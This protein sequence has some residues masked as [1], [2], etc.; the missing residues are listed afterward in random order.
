MR[1]LTEG[2]ILY[3]YEEL[4]KSAKQKANE[5]LEFELLFLAVSNL[6]SE[7]LLKNKKEKLEKKGFS[8]IEFY[9]FF[10]EDDNIKIDFS[11]DYVVNQNS[12]LDFK[13]FA[14]SI[15]LK[16]PFLFYR[17]ISDG[18]LSFTIS[19]R[20]YNIDEQKKLKHNIEINIDSEISNTELDTFLK[21]L[22]VTFETYYLYF[23]KTLYNKVKKEIEESTNNRALNNLKKRIEFYHNGL[24][25]ED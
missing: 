3:K 7:K 22:K 5:E 12:Y 21:N 2:L 25:Y 18:Q 11:F 24:I 15:D 17:Y 9:R 19:S 13:E 23:L 16:P 1:F 14:K 10:V 6:D 20:K 4:C 8:N